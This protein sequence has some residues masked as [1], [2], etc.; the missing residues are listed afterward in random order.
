MTRESGR[1]LSDYSLYELF[2]IEA[3]KQIEALTAGLLALEHDPTDLG[4]IVRMMRD[5]HSIK[6]GAS[7]VNLRSVVKLAH[8]M[9]DYLVA[10]QNKAVAI[11]Q[12]HVD[13]VLEAIDLIAQLIKL[14]ETAASVWL[15]QQESDIQRILLAMSA[16]P[17]PVSAAPASPQFPEAPQLPAA[18]PRAAALEPTEA[19]SPV[20]EQQVMRV[21]SASLDKL[22]ALASESRVSAHLL[23]P[24]LQSLQR[25]KKKQNEW[26]SE[27]D[28][29]HDLL[30]L[31]QSDDRLL[32]KAHALE[33][34]VQA[35]K[36]KM[37]ER[38]VEFDAHERRL[39][40]VSKN[41]LDEILSVRLRP[42]QDGIQSF[43]RMVRD[44]ARRLE[45]EIR[46]EVI[47]ETTL[48][49][50]NILAALETPLGHILRNAIDHGM[51]SPNQ[52]LAAGKSRDGRIQL[53]A[54]H[55]AGKLII[56]VSDDGAGVDLDKIRAKVIEK[57]MASAAMAS[58]LGPDELLDFLF[59]PAFSLKDG[60]TDISGRGVGLDIVHDMIRVHGGVV[61]ISSQTG[62][63]FQLQIT[64]PLSQSMV[65]AVIVDI[66]GE[67]YAVPIAKIEH[68]IKVAHASIAPIE[69]KPFF[70]L[71][72]QSIGMVSATQLLGL[73]TPGFAGDQIPVL[74][75][76]NDQ[77]RYGVVVDA[78]Y[79]EQNLAVQ[80]LEPIFG[81]LRD[82]SAA[83]LLDDG[84]PVLILDVADM[85]V[86]IEKLAREGALMQIGAGGQ[87]AAHKAKRILVV[88][89]SMTVREMERKL[90]SA[91]GFQV[92][93]AVDG[94][95]GWNAVRSDDYDLVI[96]D[97]DM[98]RM[99]GIELVT[100]IKKDVRLHKLPVMIV[101][102]KDRA[103]D[104]VR[105]IG[106]GADYYLTKGSFHDETLLEAVVDLIGESGI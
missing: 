4:V 30:K 56:L 96:T 48:V 22:L 64:L 101:S 90:L 42:F 84:S 76:G 82:V 60:T 51:E 106:A 39:L 80:A 65:R 95:D 46:L 69:D 32:E 26:F 98:P 105:G 61:K 1:D 73:G 93:I 6:G 3:K 54:R 17:T 78:I 102:Y 34:G 37:A 100:L 28:Q 89:D 57:G 20:R 83:S 86:S 66:A 87:R 91:R 68:V 19:Q 21:D 11:S 55:S 97:V 47:G 31:L 53:E 79:G 92:D 9:E 94:M 25:D 41:F 13:L 52:R 62:A 74:V 18:V 88:D 63:G 38:I 49:D 50:R 43:P 77:R 72:E 40:S 23:Q 27:F 58:A 2:R 15:T 5:A 85:L 103:E 36:N 104:R 45:K 33:L 12:Q 70:K 44:L 8:G 10:V 24:F 59:L 81:K 67:A 99:D 7:I 29:L 14:D 16:P 35:L 71:G 75:I